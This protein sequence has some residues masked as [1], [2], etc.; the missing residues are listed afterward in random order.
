MRVGGGP[1]K[2]WRAAA[3]VGT[4]LRQ[5][6]AGTTDDR[7]G[8]A[9]PDAR[10]RRHRLGVTC[11][12]GQKRLRKQDGKCRGKGG[13]QK[14]T[15]SRRGISDITEKARGTWRTGLTAGGTQPRRGGDARRQAWHEAERACCQGPPGRQRGAGLASSRERGSRRGLAHGVAGAARLKPTGQAGGR[16]C[17][18]RVRGWPGGGTPSS[19]RG[20]GLGS[21][22]RRRV[23]RGPP[24]HGRAVCLTRPT[25]SNVSP[26]E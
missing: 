18:R 1:G 3:P 19:S 4:R 23:R 25:D 11:S 5:K 6:P 26:L 20:L 10:V 12:T 24:A 8:P 13:T 2:G 17:F 7:N 22:G 14:R 9:A 15:K 21:W 16:W